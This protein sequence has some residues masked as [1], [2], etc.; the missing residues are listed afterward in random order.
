MPG[1]SHLQDVRG[2]N[3]APECCLGQHL[4][5][6]THHSCP[7]RQPAISWFPLIPTSRANAH[8]QRKPQSRKRALLFHKLAASCANSMEQALQKLGRLKNKHVQQRFWRPF[9]FAPPLRG[10]L[11]PP[12]HPFLAFTGVPGNPEK[13]TLQRKPQTATPLC[14]FVKRL[15]EKPSRAGRASRRLL[16]KRAPT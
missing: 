11:G 2:A 9:P 5:K 12:V 7:K 3:V 15:R 4:G 16:P 10:A 14:Q 1:E 6:L 13:E 8:R